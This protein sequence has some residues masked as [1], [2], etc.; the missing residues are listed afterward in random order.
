MSHLGIITLAILVCS[1]T[2]DSKE[3]KK[4]LT[5]TGTLVEDDYSPHLDYNSNPKSQSDLCTVH[6]TTDIVK[7]V[8]KTCSLGDKCYLKGTIKDAGDHGRILWTSLTVVR[9]LSPKK[10]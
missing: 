10:P 5:C 4:Y 1:T 2:V 8:L 3:F 6:M 9:R 7:L